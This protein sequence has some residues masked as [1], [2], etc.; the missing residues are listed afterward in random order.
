MR[1]EIWRFAVA[2]SDA[3]QKNRN[4]VAQLH[5]F[6]VQ[7]SKDISEYFTSCTTFDAHK[8]V[9]FFFGLPIRIF[10]LGTSVENRQDILNC[11]N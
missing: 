2:P 5:P 3:A 11:R 6:R 7:K 10:T 9:H 4:I 8:L 1:F